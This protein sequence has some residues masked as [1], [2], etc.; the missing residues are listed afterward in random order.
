MVEN[1]KNDNPQR[2]VAFAK[3]NF[4]GQ[5]IA[6]QLGKMYKSNEF[7]KDIFQTN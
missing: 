1:R 7:F 4:S 2:I 5:A 6:E 3:E